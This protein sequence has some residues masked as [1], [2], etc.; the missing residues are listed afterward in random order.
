MYKR[1]LLLILLLAGCRLVEPIPT[2]IPTRALTGPTLAPT[3]VFRGEVPTEAPTLAFLGASDPT[4]AALPRDSSLPPLPV[5]SVAP[6]EV[7]QT[8]EIAVGPGILMPG[9]LYSAGDQ[10][11][12]GILMLAPDSDGWLDIPLR[13]QAAG[14]SVLTMDIAN[15]ND[16]S[17]FSTLLHSFSEAGPVDPGSIAVVGAEGAA[18]MALFGCAADTLCDSVALISPT[19]RQSLLIAMQTYNPRPLFLAA[20]DGDTVAMD[21]VQSLADFA[22]GDADLQT[23]TG[24]GRG[25]DLIQANLNLGDRLIEW[26][27]GQF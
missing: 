11:V 19:Q 25:T 27:R 22:Q 6:G 26:L 13:L 3:E 4:A 14:F 21:T 7:K 9:D 18:D 20:G 24:A 8:I 23:G 12:P 10:R 17:I 2:A 15:P 1:L 5:G 16:L